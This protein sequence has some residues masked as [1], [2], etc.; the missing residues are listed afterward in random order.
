MSGKQQGLRYFQKFLNSKASER[1]ALAKKVLRYVMAVGFVLSPWLG[2]E[3]YAA[4]IERIDDLKLPSNSDVKQSYFTGNDGNV[5]NIYAEQAYNGVGLNRFKTF[6]VVDGQIANMHFKTSSTGD[7]LKSLVNTVVEKINISGTVNA[8]RNNKIGGNLVFVSPNG[9][10]LGSG[11][12]IN[13]GALSV[14][15]NDINFSTAEGAYNKLINGWWPPLEDSRIDISGQI[16]T[17]TG[18]DLRAETV[19]IAKANA[20]SPSPSVLTG[21]VFKDIVN[22]NTYAD[23]EIYSTTEKRLILTKENDQIV[24][25]N[26]ITSENVTSSDGDGMIYIRAQ[27]SAGQ[28]NYYG[29]FALTDGSIDA[30]GELQMDV[31]NR[32]DINSNSSIKANQINMYN[33]LDSIYN[34]GTI[35]GKSDV[36]IQVKGQDTTIQVNDT[37]CLVNRGTIKSTGGGITLDVKNGISNYGTINAS[38][39]IKM[40]AL[41]GVVNQGSIISQNSNVSFV[42]GREFFNVAKNDPYEFATYV[43]HNLDYLNNNIEVLIQAGGN[44]QISYTDKTTG[45]IGKNPNDTD[46]VTYAP[47]GI[48]NSST[49]RSGT[50]ISATGGEAANDSGSGNIWLTSSY[51]IENTATGQMIAGRQIT[52]NARDFLHNY[53]LIEGVTYLDIKSIMGYV[54]NHEDATI[55]ATGGNIDL[56]SGQANLVIDDDTNGKKKEEYR[57]F[58]PIIIEGIVE[59]TSNLNNTTNETNQGNINITAYLGDIYVNGG[60][61]EAKAGPSGEVKSVAGNVTLDAAQNITIGFETESAKADDP[62]TDAKKEN[63]REYYKPK[64]DETG[65]EFVNGTAAK[66]SGT[67]ITLTS[68][69]NEKY[70]ILISNTTTGSNALPASN[71]LTASDTIT[72]NTDSMNIIGGTFNASSLKSTGGLNITGSTINAANVTANG[73]LT[74]TGGS[75]TSTGNLTISGNKGLTIDSG[76]G[77]STGGDLTA[78]S[79]GGSVVNNHVLD[80]TTG[81]VILSGNTGVTNNAKITSSSGIVMTSAESTIVNDAKLTAK[82]GAVSFESKGDITNNAAIEANGSVHITST[83]GSVINKASITAGQ[84]FATPSAV[85][86][87]SLRAMAR[88]VDTGSVVISG[89]GSVT[90]N[91]D[92]TATGGSVI[93]SGSSGIEN[94]ANITASNDVSMTSSSGS[95]SNSSDST[96]T[97]TGGSVSMSGGGDVTSGN[98]TG[99]DV[100]LTGGGNVTGGTITGDGSVSMTGGGNVT[101]GT[102]TGND[103]VSMTGGGNVAVG[104][105]TGSDV[106]ITGGSD[107]DVNVDNITVDNSL[108]LQGDNITATNVNRS[109]NAT[110]ALNVDVSGADGTGS[111]AQGDVNLKIYGN[112][113]FDNLNVTDAK[114][115]TSGTL[116]ATK[117]HVE[118]KAEITSSN[119]TVNVY[120]KDVTPDPND[121]TAIQDKGDGNTGWLTLKIGDTGVQSTFVGDEAKT[122]YPVQLSGKLVDYDPYDT[123]LEQYGDVADV[124]GRTDLVVASESPSG[125]FAQGGVVVLKQDADGLRIEEEKKEE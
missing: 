24:I 39:E 97:A 109:D 40:T 16:N 88:A 36:R 27:R 82:G 69:D 81:S 96:V 50:A 117:L 120:G 2:G 73:A 32:I 122:D 37:Y 89:N 52:L 33:N 76:A 59:A 61:I 35:E 100:V 124:F 68:G 64:V 110:G 34:D 72:I 118:G 83:G 9:M 80:I 105:V 121:T 78:T 13:A 108:K 28:S 87:Y 47:I 21:V 90:N 85:S 54:Y 19:T 74:L 23:V 6:N 8:I 98:V 113:V 57:K 14:V 58:T 62:T 65:K 48:Y 94:T 4:G 67:N 11:G 53:G 56:S 75:V 84:N 30:I 66:I 3:A 17:E 45:T 119:T 104:T 55:R 51:N 123:Y 31:G 26:P 79:T 93:I 95:I 86:F 99:N 60:T 92:L 107:S 43:P 115:E 12:V 15:A 38:G 106:A 116:D 10:V 111:T 77:I 71:T 91:A 42:I 29:T 25:K 18:I 49:I 22:T 1:N 44:V 125:A 114:I 41:N 7:A 103:S 70:Y 46:T 5:A 63:E 20:K 101:C 102:I 112:V